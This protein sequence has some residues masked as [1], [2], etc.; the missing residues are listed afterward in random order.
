[1]GLRAKPTARWVARRDAA[2]ASLPVKDGD[3]T[4]PDLSLGYAEQ[5]LGPCE[6][7]QDCSWG[8]RMSS[9]LRL[10]DASG[11]IW[12]LKRHRDRE[13]HLAEVAAY[14]QWVPALGTSAPALRAF[15]S[16][17]GTIILSPVPGE[18]APWPAP[19]L[20]QLATGQRVHEAD[21]SAD[22]AALQ[23]DAGTLLRRLHEAQPA[24]PWNDFG[25]AKIDEL[26]RLRP[27]A[28]GLL[29]ARELGFAQAEVAALAGL[30]GPV[31][32][33]CHRDFT[34]RNWLVD[35]RTLYIVDFEWSRLDVW[36]SDLA[37][38][39]LGIWASR[40]D[41]RDAFLHGYGR[42]L[43]DTDQAILQGCAVLTA[44]WLLVKAHQ[45]GQGSFENASRTALRRLIDRGSR[46]R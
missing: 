31:R 32:V 30:A 4:V 23:H 40:P 14:R 18:P 34:P 28:A 27:V 24:L 42:E 12:F 7:V 9:V 36:L 26:D 37:R 38:L 45:T 16:S 13:R 15:D 21:Y 46:R 43:D 33:P 39:H 29:T 1:M 44:V 5:I 17:L 8:H 41:L 25:P 11:T 10:R 35:A 22:D 3:Q 20:D 19:A 6:L 2:N